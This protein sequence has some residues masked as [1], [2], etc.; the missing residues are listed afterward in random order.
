MWFIKLT[1]WLSCVIYPSISFY[2]LQGSRPED[3]EVDDDVVQRDAEALRDAGTDER[4][5][6]SKGKMAEL[7]LD[8][9]LVHMREVLMEYDKVRIS[10]KIY[11]WNT[12]YTAIYFI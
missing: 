2:I 5:D 6:A 7:L 8:R 4:W 10:Y 3:V 9:S 1:K 11:F 12:E